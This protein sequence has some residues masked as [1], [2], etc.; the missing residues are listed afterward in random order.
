MKIYEI[1]SRTHNEQTIQ[2]ELIRLHE[3]ITEI[4]APAVVAAPIEAGASLLSKAKSA[5]LSLLKLAGWFF[6]AEPFYNFFTNMKTASDNLK[7][8][9]SPEA[10]KKYQEELVIQVGMLVSA[11]AAGLLSRGIIRTVAGLLGFVRYIPVI[12]PIIAGI[13]EILSASAQVYVLR[14]LAS[15]KG[16]IAIANVLTGTV[17]GTQI[18][19]VK[20]IGTGVTD[21]VAFF[22]KTVNDAISQDASV[23]P[24]DE[25][26]KETPAEPTK[27]PEASAA[28]AETPKA[29]PKNP[30]ELDWTPQPGEQVYTPAGFK[31]SPSGRL[32]ISAD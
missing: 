18:N 28:P 23:K 21:A 22:T 3:S 9:S 30:D 10:Q 5:V 16:R 31:R 7:G 20:A 32:T 8:D 19:G 14:E 24:T 25:K 6:L 17:L 15:D 11:I 4:T 2:K 27:E 26:S 1:T 29:K 13:I 12:G